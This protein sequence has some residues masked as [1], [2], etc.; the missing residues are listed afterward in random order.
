MSTAIHDIGYRHYDGPRQGHGQTVRAL[1]VHN[2][3][4]L[5]GLGRGA[6]A[7]ILP[8]VLVGLLVLPSLGDIAIKAV[9]K[10]A[11]F[12]LPMEAYGFLLQPIIAIFLAAQAPVLASREI[13]FR[14]VPLYFSRPIGPWDFVAAKFGAFATALFLLTALPIT[15]LWAGFLLTRSGLI[16]A[17]R[18]NGG[19]GPGVGDIPT[20]AGITGDWGLALLGSVLLALVLSSFALLIAAFT[21]R[22]GFGVA[23]VIAVYLISNAVVG[24]VQGVSAMRGAYELG[25]WMNLFTPFNLVYGVQTS[26]LGAQESVIGM[27]PT[28]G[29]GVFF[30]FFSVLVVAGSLAAL[31]ARYRKAGA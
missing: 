25:G 5:F 13:R 15:L 8:F 26:L 11:E 27:P 31:H 7:K 20:V 3:R 17:A 12:L 22:R 18:Q 24:I 28:T 21:P 9:V 2:L 19:F 23:A 1:Y 29:A 30:V 16:E 14:T 6:K 4:T 10:E